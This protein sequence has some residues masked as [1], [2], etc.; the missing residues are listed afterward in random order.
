M[1]L[2][3][4]NTP[5]AFMNAVLESGLEDLIDSSASVSSK[6]SA[7]PELLDANLETPL[8][9][10][11]DHHIQSAGSA[12]SRRSR[13]GCVTCRKS[14]VKCDEK[15]PACSRCTRRNEA[16]KCIYLSK[17]FQFKEDFESRGATFGR[18]GVWSKSDKKK[19]G[20]Y[21]SKTDSLNDLSSQPP[22][23]YL[24]NYEE[25]NSYFLNTTVENMNG[26]TCK[27]IQSREFQYTKLSYTRNKALFFSILPSDINSNP[28]YPTSFIMS[29]YFEK[30]SP[31]LSPSST[32]NKTVSQGLYTDSSPFLLSGKE[33]KSS[34]SSGID[35]HIIIPFARSYTHVFHTL[36]ALAACH[37]S[38]TN[39]Q[40]KVIGAKYKGIALKQLRQRLQGNGTAIDFQA[41]I[42]PDVLVT[43]MLLCL[44]EI[45][46]DCDENWTVHLKA[47][48]DVISAIQNSKS[49]SSGLKTLPKDS[50][51]TPNANVPGTKSSSLEPITKMTI[52]FFAYQD[53]IGRTACGEPALFDRQYWVEDETGI[54]E[55]IGCSN[56]LIGIISDIT[57]LSYT[58][59]RCL[60]NGI[61]EELFLQ[62]EQ[63]LLYKAQIIEKELHSLS[64]REDIDYNRLFHPLKN[65]KVAD[66]NYYTDRQRLLFLSEA[67]RLATIVFLHC[68]LYDKTPADGVIS[69]YVQRILKLIK[70]IIECNGSRSSLIWPLF[71][72]SCELSPFYPEDEKEF[73]FGRAFIL[74]ACDNLNEF[75]IGNVNKTREIIAN[76]W[77][78]R[79]LAV[80]NVSG[81]KDAS[82]GARVELDKD[83]VLIYKRND[84]EEIVEPESYK[85]SLA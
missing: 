21:S 28:N 4:L 76:V 65:G 40:W 61:S 5:E 49:P 36:L 73:R 54:D 82:V 19:N 20:S 50:T 44:Y 84:W 53:I 64:P 79:D 11:P 75:T 17:Q 85:I 67:K 60:K 37:M 39:D 35:P 38:R 74:D 29:Y 3:L 46:D 23:T 42:Q 83:G 26:L 66:I 80:D 62:H 32:I 25:V 70:I 13:N 68:T 55:W 10:S 6:S 69:G 78:K 34:F 14:K 24:K 72:A 12:N 30:L 31:I 52:Q 58:R 57:D 77:K 43:M 16:D 15:L 1:G 81:P 51:I 22:V 47:A 33:V 63:E 71:V 2:S 48:R 9:V 27:D 41:A 45:A 18:E 59:R 8:S 56:I 7:A